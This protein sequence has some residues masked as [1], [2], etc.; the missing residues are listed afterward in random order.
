MKWKNCTQEKA[1]FAQE[2]EEFTPEVVEFTQEML[3]FT[4]E[5]NIIDTGSGKIYKDGK[6]YK[7][8]HGAYTGHGT[9]Y[10][11]ENLICIWKMMGFAWEGVAFTGI[12]KYMLKNKFTVHK[13]AQFTPSCGR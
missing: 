7:G 1:E 3:Q 10:I 11:G 2:V 6:I 9:I 13:R 12:R 4:H 8:D 5:K